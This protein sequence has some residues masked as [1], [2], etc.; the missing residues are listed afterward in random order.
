MLIKITSEGIAITLH[1]IAIHGSVSNCL[2]AF[3]K[4]DPWISAG[5]E[6]CAL[7]AFHEGSAQY[8]DVNSGRLANPNKNNDVTTHPI[9][10]HVALISEEYPPKNSLTT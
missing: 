3:C 8:I 4:R 6:A 7:L 2:E 1:D 9:I 5:D 10:R